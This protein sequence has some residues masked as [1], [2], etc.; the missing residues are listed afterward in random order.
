M[1]IFISYSNLDGDAVRVL[2]ED[3]GDAGYGVWLDQD[4]KG[5]DTWW[6]AIVEQIR[7]CQVF[8]VAL[9]D[10]ALRSKPCQTE[11]DYARALGIP[12]L[13]VQIGE[14]TSRRT[15]VIFEIQMVDYRNPTR[16]SAV[17]LA[18][19]VNRCMEQRGELPEPLPPPPP[20]P[21]EYL[22][23]IGTAAKARQ[24]SPKDQVAAVA[25]LRTALDQEEDEGVREDIADLLQTL[26]G[27]TDVTLR[28]AGEIDVLLSVIEIQ[29][30]KTNG[31]RGPE[32][33][34][35]TEPRPFLGEPVK[36]LEQWLPGNRLSLAAIA[37]GVVAVVF[38]PVLLGPAA[39]VLAVVAVNYTEPLGKLAIVAAIG[40]MLL[41]SYIGILAHGPI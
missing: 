10:N 24:L 41:G 15:M 33:P 21:Y 22:I 27:R 31:Y 30:G 6:R 1:G 16:R 40:G 32:R 35:D 36:P 9:S 29:D 37:L 8:V 7:N 28:T 34:L 11:L 25:E 20:I 5:G 18:A 14:I 3:L 23:R 38:F 17:R 13:P 26:R 19:A 2:A 39:F 12:V 4:L